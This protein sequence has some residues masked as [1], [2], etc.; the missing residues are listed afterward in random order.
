MYT[1]CESTNLLAQPLCCCHDDGRGLSGRVGRAL[2]S[3]SWLL[4]L[5]AAKCKIQKGEGRLLLRFNESI[6]ADTYLRQLFKER[7]QFQSQRAHPSQESCPCQGRSTI[8]ITTGREGGECFQAGFWRIEGFI[9]GQIRK[10]RGEPRRPTCDDDLDRFLG[11]IGSISHTSEVSEFTI[12]SRDSAD[13]CECPSN[14]VSEL[15]LIVNKV[16]P[17]RVEVGAFS[18]LCVHSG[19]FVA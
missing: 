13:T 3:Q 12:D 16:E 5:Q 10:Q 6:L 19:I 8:P 15:R 2:C 17:S 4:N 1:T 14:Q 11:I 18:V 9:V 7:S